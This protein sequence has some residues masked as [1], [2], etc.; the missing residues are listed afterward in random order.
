MNEQS[1]EDQYAMGFCYLK[2]RVVETD[3]SEAVKWFRK[4]A[5]QNYA[6]AQL[7][8]GFCYEYGRGVR[9]DRAEAAKWYSKANE[10]RKADQKTTN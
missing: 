8:L 4:A 6:M 9:K 1:A 10:Q 3:Y 2:G 5:E 7:N